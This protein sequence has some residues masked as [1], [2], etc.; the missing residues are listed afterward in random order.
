MTGVFWLIQFQA[1]DDE[2]HILI[3]FIRTITPQI[4][5]KF[6]YEWWWWKKK[7][8]YFQVFYFPPSWV[9]K[10]CTLHTENSMET[11][12]FQFGVLPRFLVVSNVLKD[13]LSG[14]WKLNFPLEYSFVLKLHQVFLIVFCLKPNFPDNKV[15][16]NIQRGEGDL[17]NRWSIFIWN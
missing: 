17:Y 8:T 15:R 2:K 14:K 13:T 1:D 11:V 7:R 16:W 6:T 9:V 5:C 10:T 12:D 4:E 3:D